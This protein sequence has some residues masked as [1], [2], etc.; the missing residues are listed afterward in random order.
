MSIFRKSASILVLIIYTTVL[1]VSAQE[2]QSYNRFQYSANSHHWQAFHTSAFHIYFPEGYDS[3]CA[4][5]SAE[6]PDAT[7]LLRRRMGSSISSVP[8]IIIYP[9][10]DQVYESN[11]GSFE[12]GDKTLPTFITKGNRLLLAYQGN[13]EGL[14]HQLYEGL[15]RATWESTLNEGLETQLTGSTKGL[16]PYWMKEGMI[17]YFAHQWPVE[18][19]DEV[20]ALLRDTSLQHWDAVIANNPAL[21][22]QAFCYFLTIKYFR[23]APTQL[24]LQLRKRKPLPRVLRLVTKEEM[25]HLLDECLQFYR[26]R[27]L[28]VSTDTSSNAWLS[29]A[30]KKGRVLHTLISPK[31]TAVAYVLATW[32]QRTVYVYDVPGKRHYKISSYQLP[33]WIND[34]AGDDYPLVSWSKAG[35][36]LLVTQPDKG[37]ITV[38]RYGISGNLRDKYPM[39]GLDG[40]SSVI[41]QDN[42]NFLL[43][44]WN[45]GQSDIVSYNPFKEKYTLLT[46]D[47]FDDAAPAINEKYKVIYFVSNRPLTNKKEDSICW[48]GIFSL[49]EKQVSFVTVDQES[50]D[51]RW[52][53]PQVFSEGRII[54]TTTQNGRRQFADLYD[55]PIVGPLFQPAQF[56][57]D[58]KDVLISRC[59]RDRLFITRQDL[60]SWMLDSTAN[61]P[62]PWLLDYQQAAAIRAKEDS[63]LKA[64]ANTEPSFLDGVFNTANAKEQSAKR[65][66]SIH[67]ALRY[68]PKKASPYV[69]QLYSA[70]FTAKVNNDYFIN[71]YQPYEAYQGSFRFPQ[72]G[73][74][75][76]G[77]FSDLFE[78]HHINIAFR[79]PAGSDGSDFFVKYRNTAKL[80]DWGLAYYR[81]SEDLK[82]DPQRNWVDENGRLYPNV[83]RA[84]TNYYELSLEY[85]LSHFSAVRLQ[86]AA[87]QDKT[88]FPATEK[89]SLYF[90]AFKSLWGLFTLSYQYDRLQPSLPLL[91][92]GFSGKLAIDGFKGFTQQQKA[93]AGLSM[94]AAYHLPVYRYITL[95]AQLQ[96]GYSGGDHRVLYNLGGVD[97]NITPRVDSNVHFPQAAPYA[98]QT[99]VTPL[100]GYF[101]NS[102]YGSSYALLNLDVYF[103][104][105]QTLIPIETPLSA[106]NNLQPGLFTDVAKAGGHALY[107][108]KEKGW[109]AA[110]GLSARTTL[111]GY[112]LRFDMGWPGAGGKPVWYLSLLKPL[113]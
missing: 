110:Y 102:I 89:Y 99:L 85:P 32:H 6:A 14:K 20:L 1:P 11:I 86:L 25:P 65:Q 44:A 72:I 62:S 21:A 16:V 2:V 75:A 12:P 15:A 103:P 105:F 24:F 84:K 27:L 34:H 70:Y 78:N 57:V 90:P 82:P 13:R 52:Q 101:Q 79:L 42:N 5:I 112:P 23:Q 66:D 49:K 47:Q 17:C 48:Q 43:A 31:Q 38:R 81:K 26:Q 104:L 10:P 94:K 67:N 97:N 77:G 40:T 63:I 51:V 100:R 37:H 64:V 95:V 33:P 4:Q 91:Y 29:L 88:I 58:G 28:P 54:A 36:E 7:E 107:S 113:N 106:I 92:K 73:G 69:L 39:K 19:E 61:Q 83:A 53:F 109:Q 46:N 56:T 96:A 60:D 22:G 87:R 68:D 74:M 3:L 59:I 35:D 98:F 108:T 80:L 50:N 93:L 8:N 30:H 111:A 45:K 9:S 18:R 76:Q 41:M 71:R 55:Q